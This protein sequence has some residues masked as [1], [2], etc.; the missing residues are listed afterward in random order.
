[1]ETLGPLKGVYADTAPR[2]GEPNGKEHGGLKNQMGKWK[3]GLS[4]AL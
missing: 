2:N 3:L 1:M 4:C